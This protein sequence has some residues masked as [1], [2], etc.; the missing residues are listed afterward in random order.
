MKKN[1]YIIECKL[2]FRNK[3]N[4]DVIYIHHPI[5]AMLKN[6]IKDGKQLYIPQEGVPHYPKLKRNTQHPKDWKWY[7]RCPKE[8]NK[9]FHIRPIRAQET[10]WKKECMTFDEDLLYLAEERFYPRYK[11]HVYYY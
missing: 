2:Y 9:T 8:W 1:Y 10:K 11:H 3:K 5:F 6:P 4:S 7:K